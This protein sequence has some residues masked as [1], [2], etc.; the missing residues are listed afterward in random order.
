MGTEIL[1]KVNDL[2][3]NYGKNEYY[4]IHYWLFR[5]FEKI[6]IDVKY[7]NGIQNEEVYCSCLKDIKFRMN[8]L[9]YSWDETKERYDEALTLWNR[10]WDLNLPFEL[11]IKIIFSIDIKI[12]NDNYLFEIDK[13][14][15][16]I[17][18][19]LEYLCEEDLEF[20]KYNIEDLDSFTNVVEFLSNLNS[21]ILIR[22]FCEKEENL[23]FPLR[24]YY[25]E[26][27][28]N[29]WSTI[30]DIESYD[31]NEFIIQ[32][33]ILYGK[34]QETKLRDDR[35]YYRENEL[36]KWFISMGIR[37]D[38][39]YK[40]VLS[41]GTIRNEKKTLPV[42][43]RNIIHHPENAHNSFNPKEL[44]DS[45]NLMLDILKKGL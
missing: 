30:D 26:H 32:H 23:D 27:M 39:T 31:K 17:A 45:V 41:D 33:N 21:Y 13:W 3:V 1:L 6:N 15:H 22:I 35:K 4:K 28:N 40:R 29:G 11:L 18:S 36:N 12:I 2:T 44:L 43:I 9:G 37:N 38:K 7:S 16:G 8:N 5:D 34:I 42:Y 24:W 19:Y 25:F 20:N 10:T 14:E